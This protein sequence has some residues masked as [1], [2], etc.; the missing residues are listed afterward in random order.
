MEL[1]RS[2]RESLTPGDA[3]VDR[4]GSSLKEN[5]FEAEDNCADNF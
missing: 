3:V 4:Y 2:K 5:R 1:Y